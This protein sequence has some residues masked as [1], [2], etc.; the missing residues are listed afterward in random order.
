MKMGCKFRVSAARQRGMPWTVKIVNNNHN[1]EPAESISVLLQ[2]RIAAMSE[3]ERG[4]VSEMHQL[5]HSL[6]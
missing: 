4:I 2:H 6:I 3:K 1:H 5:G